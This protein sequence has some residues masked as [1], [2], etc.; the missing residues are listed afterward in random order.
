MVLYPSVKQH[1][2]R[3]PMVSYA[4]VKLHFERLPRE[5][6]LGISLSMIFHSILADYGTTL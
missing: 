6:T 5:N 1:L 3:L 4:S 2:E